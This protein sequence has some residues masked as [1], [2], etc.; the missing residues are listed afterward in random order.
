MVGIV[1]S[2]ATH[3]RDSGEID[4][5]MRLV[6]LLYHCTVLHDEVISRHCA[7][8]TRAKVI[9]TLKDDNIGDTMLR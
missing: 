6:A 1:I 7:I 2:T 9:D 5:L 8:T 4:L 3:R